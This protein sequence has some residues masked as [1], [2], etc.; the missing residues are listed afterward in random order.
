MVLLVDN[1]LSIVPGVLASALLSVAGGTARR[2]VRPAGPRRGTSFARTLGLKS[3]CYGRL[4]DFF[5]SL[6]L[7]VDAS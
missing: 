7:C 5:H 1:R 4:L 6:A 3:A 2:S